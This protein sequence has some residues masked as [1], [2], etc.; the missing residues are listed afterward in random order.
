MT[1]DN[2]LWARITMYACEWPDY[3]LAWFNMWKY[4][5]ADVDIGWMEIKDYFIGV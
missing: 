2:Y 4:T 5:N 1:V 3:F